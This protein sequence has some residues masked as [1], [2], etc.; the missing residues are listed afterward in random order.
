MIFTY[1]SKYNVLHEWG[2]WDSETSEPFFGNNE[3]FNIY[4]GY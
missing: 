1:D 4:V 3:I 2:Y